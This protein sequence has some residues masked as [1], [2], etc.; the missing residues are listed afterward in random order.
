[1]KKKHLLLG[2][3]L[4]QTAAAWAMDEELE[5]RRDGGGSVNFSPKEISKEASLL[6]N[7][8]DLNS[9][10]KVATLNRLLHLTHDLSS[11]IQNK[12]QH[13]LMT[14]FG[15]SSGEICSLWKTSPFTWEYHKEKP[16]GAGALYNRLERYTEPPKKYTIFKTHVNLV[17]AI[18]ENLLLFKKKHIVC[19][20]TNREIKKNIDLF[21]K[22][23][24]LLSKIIS[25]PNISYWALQDDLTDYRQWLGDIESN[26]SRADFL[27]EAYSG[28]YDW[29]VLR[30]S[31]FLRELME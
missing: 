12:P 1:M 31:E 2:I 10:G 30:S 27:V 19:E 17:K 24:I 4:I 15:N 18:A 6:P 13:A 23:M 14:L 11:D 5:F 28:L 8:L 21:G 22:H 26:T 25:A 16:S 3:F 7:F 20:T 9:Y 29:E